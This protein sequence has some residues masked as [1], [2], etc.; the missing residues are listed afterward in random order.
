MF[1]SGV[2]LKLTPEMTILL[3]TPD[4]PNLGWIW[5]PH[6]SGFLRK[7]DPIFRNSDPNTMV[8]SGLIWKFNP[9][10]ALLP[11][12]PQIWDGSGALKHGSGFHR[13]PDPIFG[14][15]EPF[16]GQN[17]VGFWGQNGGTIGCPRVLLTPPTTISRTF[18]SLTSIL[19]QR[20]LRKKELAS[21]SSPDM[22]S[23]RFLLSSTK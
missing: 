22:M 5:Y 17:G 20:H 19:P 6:G 9:E 12:I 2:N 23:M 16:L 11:Q 1:L 7:P 10:M 3:A 8:F 13:K 4:P 21:K 18:Y 15:G 14:N